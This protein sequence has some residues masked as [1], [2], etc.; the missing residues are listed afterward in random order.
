[1]ADIALVLN[2]N[3]R[4]TLN[5]VGNVSRVVVPKG[6]RTLLIDSPSPFYWE[7]GTQSKGDGDAQTTGNQF[8]FEGGPIDL[9]ISGDGGEARP[10]A[11]KAQTYYYF[12]ATVASQEITFRASSLVGGR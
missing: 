6:T 8:R 1:M 10:G 2:R 4:T 12:V 9:Q 7:D 11:L 5:A 3:K